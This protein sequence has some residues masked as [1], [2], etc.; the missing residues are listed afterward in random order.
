MLQRG[1][2]ARGGDP[3]H[4]PSRTADLGHCWTGAIQ[5][6]YDVLLSWRTGVPEPGSPVNTF[7][8]LTHTFAHMRALVRASCS[9]MT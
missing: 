1:G 3:P 5:D 8:P 9:S 2:T 4:A 6:Y 7:P